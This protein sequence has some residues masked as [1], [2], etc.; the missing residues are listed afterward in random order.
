VVL[1]A[2][3]PSGYNYRASLVIKITKS[4]GLVIKFR[5]FLLRGIL[6]ELFNI[7]QKIPNLIVWLSSVMSR[8]FSCFTPQQK[9][10]G[11]FIPAGAYLHFGDGFLFVRG[12]CDC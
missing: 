6:L 10:F 9:R 7:P 12:V 2:I 3:L 5:G 1:C 11:A 8:H 4:P